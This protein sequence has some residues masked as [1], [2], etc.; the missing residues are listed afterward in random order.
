MSDEALRALEAAVRRDPTRRPELVAARKRAGRTWPLWTV[1]GT[2]MGDV[3]DPPL[4]TPTVSHCADVVNASEWM[5]HHM[6]TVRTWCGRAEGLLASLAR[7]DPDAIDPPTCKAC[8]R[9]RAYR[10]RNPSA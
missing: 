10:E 4:V 2:R 7:I 9:T 1:G 5:G 3:D 6:T 8:R